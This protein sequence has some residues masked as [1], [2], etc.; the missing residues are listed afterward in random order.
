M[1]QALAK[2]GLNG[3]F[4]TSE[5]S[6][7]DPKTI[8]KTA[9]ESLLSRFHYLS[10]VSGGGYIGSWLS[11]W[12][13]RDDFPTVWKNL[14]GRPDG[15]D[16]EPPEISWLRA[17][18]NYLTPKVGIGSADTWTGAAIFLRNL[19]LNWLVIVPAVA[20]ILLALKFIITGSVAVA[21]IDDVW[22]PSL[23]TALVGIAFLIVA[24]AF[25]TGHRPTRRL[26]PKADTSNDPNNVSETTYLL[27]DLA[28]SLLSALFLTSALTSFVGVELAGGFNV[29]TAI[30]I[31]AAFA[32][33][34]FAAGWL[35]GNP[36]YL[37]SRDFAMWAL[38]GLVYGGLVGFGAHLYAVTLPNLSGTWAIWGILLPVI[39]GVPWV[40]MSQLFAEMVFVGLVSYEVNSD[41][42]REWLGRAAGWVAA[43]AVAWI[44]ATFIVFA[45][46]Y[47]LIDIYGKVVASYIASAGG[48]TAVI[49]GWL[50]KS[51]KTPAKAARRKAER[52]G[53]GLQYRTCHCRPV[54]RRRSWWSAYRSGSTCCCSANP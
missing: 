53:Y 5:L 43:A 30:G 4:A 41:A 21:R 49:T 15:P 48:I 44:A 17:Y 23:L 24:Q 11:A 27:H 35:T 34:I 29:Y 8:A 3:P 1:I 40:L 6:V 51:A 54:F 22:W 26:R 36:L 31:G 2:H 18:S 38:S 20:V 39:L 9:N 28:P 14:T 12:R 46:S 33:V 13:T 32:V 45:G 37:R 7:T 19:I 52:N 42:D 25:T 16:V 10:T 50:G 47:L